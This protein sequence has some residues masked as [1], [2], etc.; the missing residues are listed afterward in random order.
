MKLDREL[1][2]DIVKSITNLKKYGTERDEFGAKLYQ[3]I[4]NTSQVV[5][6]DVTELTD[7]ELIA[8]FKRRLRSK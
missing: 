2:D 8:E 7:V 5:A 3:I 4:L 1:H 6:F